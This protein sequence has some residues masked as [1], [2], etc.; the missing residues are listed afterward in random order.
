MGIIDYDNKMLRMTKTNGDMS[1]QY[2]NLVKALTSPLCRLLMLPRP[3]E[4]MSLL[5]E[6]MFFA[7]STR[8]L[9]LEMKGSTT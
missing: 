1:L 4:R 9:L 8:V 6:G 7:W 5:K 2:S 3:T